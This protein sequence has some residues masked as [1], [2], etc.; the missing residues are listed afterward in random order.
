MLNQFL[1]WILFNVFVLAMLALDLGVFHRKAHEVKIKEALIWSAVWITL[2]LIFNLGIYFWRGEAAA[3]EFLTGY[4][5]E[6]SLSVDNIFV[7]LLIFSYFRVDPL[8]QHKILFWG[9]LGALI[10]RAIFIAVGVTL[11]QQFHWV[12]YVFGAFLILTGIKMALQK[13]KEIHPEKNPAL[14]LFRRF[15]PITDHSVQGK[16]FVKLNGRT[17]ATPLFVVLLVVET[18]DLIFAVDSIPAVLAITLDPFIVYTSN[19]FAIL[20]LRALYFALA[21]AMRLF[22]YLHLGLSS[23][24]VFIGAKMLLADIYRIPIVIALSVVAGILVIS[25][26]ASL[27]RLRKV[28]VSTTTFNKH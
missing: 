13:D 6:K 3:L 17:F 24:L 14:R 4:L 9:I 23:I 28:E 15:M 11:I 8:Y 1:P 7:F 12:I 22:H 18:T 27:F 10:M 25:V 26:V 5:L 19:V 21:G 2:A 16:F 20:G